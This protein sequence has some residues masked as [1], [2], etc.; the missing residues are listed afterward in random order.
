M[1]GDWAADYADCAL[2]PR[3][4]RTDRR[5]G[6]RGVCGE[7]AECHV[8]SIGP[9]F[10]E[11][12][13]FSGTR[14][15]GAIFFRG[16]ACRCF[17]C[18]NH[19]IS[20][21]GVGAPLNIEAL[22]A[23][24]EGLVAQGVHNLNFVT[25][26]HFWPHIAELA[27]RLRAADH[28]IPLLLNTSGYVL[29][30]RVPDYARWMDIFLPDYK[31][32]DPDLARM[33]M[34]DARYPDLALAAL[35]EMVA[36]RGFLHPMDPSGRETAREGVLVRH[37]VLP[38]EVEN[39]IAALR[40]LRDEFGPRLPLSVMSQYRPVPGCRG[41]GGFE[42]RLQRDEYA[43]VRAAVEELEFESVFVQELDD[44]DAFFPD[45]ESDQPFRGNA[46]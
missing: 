13:C 6:R 21:G 9:H 42:R 27:R 2:C 3:R 25:G 33:C 24:A 14:G 44:D 19:Q 11:E 39:S 12:P 10:G 16:C 20:R 22:F 35:R 23:A 28:R 8:A 4:C 38:G 15:S 45:F 36:A 5:A 29:S 30:E 46:R 34:G 37:L 26:D 41:R 7:T 17:F 40:R 43:A 31:F 32:A 18:Q 1:S